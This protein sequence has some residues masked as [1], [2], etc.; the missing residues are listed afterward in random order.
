VDENGESVKV[1]SKAKSVAKADRPIPTASSSLS[2]ISLGFDSSSGS[3]LWSSGVAQ[4]SGM[5]QGRPDVESIVAGGLGIDGFLL[6][7]I[8]VR[9]CMCLAFFVM[10]ALLIVK[11]R[12]SIIVR[13]DG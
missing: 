2:A 1:C 11:H 6:V 7:S 4:G 10:L 9:S 8:S 12:A 13:A 5:I 3:K